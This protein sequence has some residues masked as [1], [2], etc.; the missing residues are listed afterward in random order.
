MYVMKVS[1]R[2]E[3]Q[4]QLDSSP[5]ARHRPQASTTGID[6]NKYGSQSRS[7]ASLSLRHRC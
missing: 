4:G 1:D 7:D 3:G 5:R 2:L 6:H